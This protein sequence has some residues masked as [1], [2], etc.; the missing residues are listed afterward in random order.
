[1]TGLLLQFPLCGS[2]N[3]GYLNFIE[4][5]NEWMLMAG[6]A[7]IIGNQGSNYLF[8]SGSGGNEMVTLVIAPTDDGATKTLIEKP[9]AG[10]RFYRLVR[11]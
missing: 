1:M 11:P 6:G 7:G 8:T 5:T 2:L 3:N 9:L 10:N 4:N